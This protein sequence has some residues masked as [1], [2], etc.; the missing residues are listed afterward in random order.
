[1]G[2]RRTVS[3][4]PG[5]CCVRR[6]C[7][8]QKRAKRVSLLC[9][10]L[11]SALSCDPRPFTAETQIAQRARRVHLARDQ[12][13]VKSHAARIQLRGGRNL[14]IL[15]SSRP[16]NRKPLLDCTTLCFA[17]D[18]RRGNQRLHFLMFTAIARL[19]FGLAPSSE[20]NTS[21]VSRKRV[22]A[23]EPKHVMKLTA[24]RRISASPR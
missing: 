13:A 12:P 17:R 18:Y 16:N 15:R 3:G 11:R 9:S 20:L 22:L 2:S 10:F 7:G 6:V 4:E 21:L 8:D 19:L 1:M 23:R 5:L 24:S 14:K